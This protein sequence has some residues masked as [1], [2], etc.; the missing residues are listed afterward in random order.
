MSLVLSPRCIVHVDANAFFAALE[1]RDNPHLRG[2][3]VAVGS[4]VVA[5]CSHEARRWGVRTGMR[6]GDARR[7]CRGLHVLAGDY[8]RYE[9]AA[10]RMLAICL[11]QTPRVEVAALD[12]LYLDLTGQTDAPERVCA[13]LAAQMA[14]EIGLSVAV[15]IGANKLVANVATRQAKKAYRGWSADG[16]VLPVVHVPVGAERDYLAG[17]PVA[18]LP[19]VG[20]QVQE[21]LGQIN[22]QQVGQLAA[23]PPA[24]LAGLFGQRGLVLRQ[25]AQ[26]I[27]HRPVDPN[28]VQQAVSRSTSLEPPT[29]DRPFLHALVIHLL[30][31]AALWLRSRELMTRGLTVSLRYGDHQMAGGRVSLPRP[32]ADERPLQAAACDRLDRLYVRRLPLRWLGVE[33]APLVAIDRQAEL[34][35]DP[36]RERAERLT[37]CKDAVRGRFGFMSLCSGTALVLAQQLQ[38]DRDNFQLRTPCLTR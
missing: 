9:Q 21:R 1:Q 32:C 18:V 5:S 27:D 38:H 12:D 33:L 24:V 8:R 29:S 26:G 28:R 3:P 19:G 37:Q 34:F 35:P 23:M 4:G 7:L 25:L 15:G 20:P 36:Q 10:R 22:V 31:R 13:Q 6:L 17:W 16:R 30:D 11:E 14:E 2:R